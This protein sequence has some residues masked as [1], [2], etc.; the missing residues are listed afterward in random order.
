MQTRKNKG[1]LFI[2]SAPSGTGKTTLCKNILSRIPSLRFSVSYTTR[3]PRANEVNNN[4]YTFISKEEFREMIRRDEFLEWAEV[5]GEFYGTS[6][7]RVEELTQSGFDVLLDIDVQGAMQIKRNYRIGTYI[8]ILPPSLDE[9]RR[10]LEKRGT[11]SKVELEKRL[12]SAIEEIKNY[13]YYE[14]VIINKDIDLA[15]KEFE[16]IILSQR[17]KSKMIDPVWVKNTFFK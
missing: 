15:I 9:L 12:K 5:Y 13:K 7:K 1:S 2:V 3:K 17:L 11:D 6:K 8:F 4:D 10:R 14:Y 16:A